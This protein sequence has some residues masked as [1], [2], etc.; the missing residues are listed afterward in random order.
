M[1]ILAFLTEDFAIATL[2]FDLAARF[3]FGQHSRF[4]LQPGQLS[5]EPR[6]SIFVVSG[7][8]PAPPVF[9]RAS[10]VLLPPWF[11]LRSSLVSVA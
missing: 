4:P 8:I 10:W 9:L 11:Q 7:L 1:S 3:W 6:C 5:S 2:I